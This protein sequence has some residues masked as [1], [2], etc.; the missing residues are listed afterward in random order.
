M[1]WNEQ[2]YGNLQLQLGYFADSS[3][4]S[5]VV[6]CLPFGIDLLIKS[7]KT[8][9][10]TVTGFE[11]LDF[12][13]LFSFESTRES[14]RSAEG[15]N[16]ELLVGLLCLLNKDVTVT[17]CLVLSTLVCFYFDTTY[18]DFLVSASSNA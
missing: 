15:S 17:V 4:F 16:T 5:R 2:Q 8:M 12:F 9:T 10:V 14:T 3:L 18:R 7:G 13:S 11:L 6:L 1:I